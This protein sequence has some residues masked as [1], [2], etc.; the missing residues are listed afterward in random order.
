M[1]SLHRTHMAGD[2]RSSPIPLSLAQ[3][4]AQFQALLK[5]LG[6]LAMSNQHGS[7]PPDP[8]LPS[9]RDAKSEARCL[10]MGEVG[11]P[12]RGSDY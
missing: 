1:L 2:M 4:V 10:A 9:G 6:S 3:P 11:T 5:G 12:S 8:S 7:S